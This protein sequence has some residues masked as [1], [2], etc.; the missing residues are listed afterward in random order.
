M[1]IHFRQVQPK[2]WEA[3][4]KIENQGFSPAE[5]ASRAAMKERIENI[6][7]AFIVAAKQEE[8]LG[9]IVGPT[10]SQC[11]LTD[12]YSSILYLITKVMLI[13]QF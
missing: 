8:I 13:K 2:D 5:A 10:F 11:Y 3:I 7:E 9:Y 4:M 1:K 6:Q 12:E